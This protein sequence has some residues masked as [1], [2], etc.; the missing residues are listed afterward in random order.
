MQDSLVHQ[1]LNTT[2]PLGKYVSIPSL[3]HTKDLSVVL[4]NISFSCS[5]I[6]DN[7]QLVN[8]HYTEWNFLYTLWRYTISYDI[9]ERTTISHFATAN[10]RK[11][12]SARTGDSQF[13]AKLHLLRAPIS[14]IWSKLFEHLISTVKTHNMPFIKISADASSVDFYKKMAQKFSKYFV[15]VDQDYLRYGDWWCDFVFRLQ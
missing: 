3:E 2:I 1:N 5:P 10:L 4:H 12:S 15:G 11:L 9:H 13:A 7:R 8:L 14:W 6:K